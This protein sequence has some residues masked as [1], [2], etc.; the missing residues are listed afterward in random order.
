[1]SQVATRTVENTVAA[2]IAAER[3]SIQMKHFRD[4]ASLERCIKEN[5][6]I[7]LGQVVG[8]AVA[9]KE[10]EGTLPNGEKN[11]SLLIIGEFEAT[12]YKTGEIFSSTG[13]YLPRYFAETVEAALARAPSG[14]AFGIEVLVEPTG[15]SVVEG[16]PYSYAVKRLVARSADNPL[17]A[18]KRDMARAGTLRLPAAAAPAIEGGNADPIAAIEQER[19]GTAGAVAA[20]M[21][22]EDAEDAGQG[23]EDASQQPAG[24][25]RGRRAA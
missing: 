25:G 14:I 4:T 22:A 23:A 2:N 1:M 8:Y 19:G 10:K 21:A 15:K 16:I 12:N 3:K 5:V 20:A 7:A 9:V 6:A 13:I 11:K 24:K 17:E 18:M